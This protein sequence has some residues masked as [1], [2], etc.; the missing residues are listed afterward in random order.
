MKCENCG[1][2]LDWDKNKGMFQCG[3]S[4]RF[5]H[6]SKKGK[7]LMEIASWCSKKCKDCMI[8][9]GIKSCT[10]EKEVNQDE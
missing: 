10:K 8:G 4:K 3:E 9:S 6:F 5:Y 2:T 7:K 1:K